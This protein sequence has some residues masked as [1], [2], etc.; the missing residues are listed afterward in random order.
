MRR[1]LLPLLLAFTCSGLLAFTDANTYRGGMV[2]FLYEYLE[3]KYEEVEFQDFIYVAAKR[4]RLY[5]IRNHNVV[6][7]YEISTSKY[8]IGSKAKSQKTPLGLHSVYGKFGDEVPLGGILEGR[9]YTG[10][11]AEIVKEARTIDTDDVTSR[12]LWLRGL[13][14]GVNAGEG[15]DSKARCIYIHGTPEE[16]L[17]GQPASHGCIRMRNEDVIELYE[18]VKR[19]T[20][21]V[22]LNN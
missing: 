1:V 14:E 10:R 19:G 2:D 18:L 11:Q 8:G 22:I 6:K 15:I 12:V 3:L 13:E 5:H 4:Q 20:Y 16:G 9:K 21:V 7:R 17:I